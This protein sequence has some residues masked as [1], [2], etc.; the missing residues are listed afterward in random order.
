MTAAQLAKILLLAFRQFINTFAKE[1]GEEVT[2]Q[3]CR[4]IEKHY[5]LVPKVGQDSSKE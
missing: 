2:C 3:R 5:N 4:K 1:I